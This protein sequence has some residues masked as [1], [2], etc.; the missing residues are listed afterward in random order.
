VLPGHEYTA[1]ETK[2][3]NL[4]VEKQH[5]SLINKIIEYFEEVGDEFEEAVGHLP[6]SELAAAAEMLVNITKFSQR[7]SAEQET[8]GGPVDV[9]LITKGDGFVW[10]KK[11]QCFPAAL[12]PPGV[13]RG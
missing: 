12:N 2:K 10:V 1:R 13:S 6:K 5:E 3:L 4:L 11:K 8:V 7:V 9:A